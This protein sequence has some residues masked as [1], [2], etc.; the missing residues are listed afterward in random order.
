MGEI[1]SWL[2]DEGIKDVLGM[3]R[4]NASGKEGVGRKRCREVWASEAA[5]LSSC[6]VP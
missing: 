1:L 5:F 6:C 4:A 2:T 3:K